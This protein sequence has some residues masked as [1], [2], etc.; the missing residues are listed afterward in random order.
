VWN[1]LSTSADGSQPPSLPSKEQN[2]LKG[3]HRAA[4]ATSRGV[5]GNAR[6][7][8]CPPIERCFSQ[9]RCSM[10]T[11]RE[12][13]FANALF[14]VHP[15]RGAFRKCAV[16]CPPFR[17]SV[18]SLQQAQRARG[19]RLLRPLGDTE[20]VRNIDRWFRKCETCSVSTHRQVVSEMRCSVSTHRQVLS[21]MPALF[22]VH[23]LGCP[24]L[25]SNSRNAP[26]VLRSYDL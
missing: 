10:S 15:S 9:M 12:V 2:T 6:P 20:H 11:H 22:G 8:Q 7:V 14:N 26:A 23:P 3:G 13:L 5:F 25:P 24:F 16:R 17:V 21:E 1:V 4:S 18:P 19:T